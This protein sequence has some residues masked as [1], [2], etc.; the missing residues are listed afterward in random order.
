MFDLKDPAGILA[1]IRECRKTFP[2]QYVRVTGYDRRFGR[3]TTAL[4]FIVQRP[5]HEPG[6]RLERQESNDRVVRYQLHSYATEKPAG[7]R[8]ENGGA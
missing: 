6:F 4:S 5:A 1:E 7:E 2:N 3:Q 8:Y